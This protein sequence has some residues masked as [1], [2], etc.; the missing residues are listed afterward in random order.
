MPDTAADKRTIRELVENWA[1]W[2]DARLWDQ[3]RTVWQEDGRMMATWFQGSFEEFIKVNNEGWA[4]GV[5]ILHFLGGSTI[6]VSGNRAIAQT[7]MTISQRA[8]VEDVICD[9]VCTGRF[10]DFF[11]RRNGRWGLVLRQPIYEKDRLDPVD[12]AAKLTLDQKLL[13][14]FPEG[15]RHLAYLQTKIGYKVK[16]DMPGID[17]PELEALYARGA[18]WLRGEAL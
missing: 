15:Y 6:E 1:I 18:R 12:P 17:G 10:Y 13:M 11:D 8:P 14:R 4:R 2:R 5:R 7:K 16:T 3:F 9:V